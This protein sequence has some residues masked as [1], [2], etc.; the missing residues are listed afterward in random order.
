MGKTPNTGGLILQL[1]PAIVNISTM[2]NEYYNSKY[3]TIAGSIIIKLKTYDMN[4]AQNN[5]GSMKLE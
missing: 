1:L 5:P 3:Q 2:N 4:N